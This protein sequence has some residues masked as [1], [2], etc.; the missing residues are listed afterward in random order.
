MAQYDFHYLP[1]E[2][3]ITGKQVLQQT[4]DAINDLGNRIANIETDT[5]AISEAVEIAQDAKN[6]ADNAETIANDA[7][8]VARAE[9]ESAQEAAQEANQAATNASN[10]ASSASVTAQQLM[11]YLATKEELT[12]PAVDPTLTITGAA[13]DANITGGE[14]GKVE[15]AI[16]DAVGRVVP[17]FEIGNYNQGIIEY[18]DNYIVPQD[19]E[20]VLREVVPGA[21]IENLNYYFYF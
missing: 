11:E 16:A 3:K 8:D 1:L 9:R 19:R 7:M 15:T 5:E 12:A 20:R 21:I 17:H 13:A 14:I 4:E 10:S 18:A 6:V 2:G